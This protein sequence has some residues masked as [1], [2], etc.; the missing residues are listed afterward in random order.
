MKL[1]TKAMPDKMGK[2]D[3]ILLLLNVRVSSILI[4]LFRHQVL[5]FVL[6]SSEN[7]DLSNYC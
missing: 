5:N 2:I 6:F 1:K 4:V 7:L 3:K